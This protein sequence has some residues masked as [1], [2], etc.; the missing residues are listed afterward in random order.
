MF[1]LV[2]L[3]L[4]VDDVWGT[5]NEFFLRYPESELIWVG[6]GAYGSSE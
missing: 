4:L 1:L 3:H 6:Y 5:I 2:F